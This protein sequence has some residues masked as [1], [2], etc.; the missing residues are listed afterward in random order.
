MDCIQG[1]GNCLIQPSVSGGIAAATHLDLLSTI[2]TY[3]EA[4][5]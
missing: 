5:S 3:Q 4:L 1:K 2:F